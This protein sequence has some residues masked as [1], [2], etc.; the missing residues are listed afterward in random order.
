MNPWQIEIGK[1]KLGAPW[2]V[3]LQSMT[4]TPTMD[5]QATVEQTI[6]I[7][8]AGADI[9]RITAQNTKEAQN[10]AFIKKE[11]NKRSYYIPLV[12]D[13]HF[14]PKAAD[15]AAT[16][17]DKVRIN[18]G[19]Y[20]DKKSNKIEWTH[21]EYQQDLQHI[22]QNLIGLVDI[23]Q[24]HHTA[25]RVGVNHGSLSERIKRN[26]GDTVEGMVESAMEFINIF[27]ELNFENLVISLK[28]SNVL[29]MVEANRLLTKRMKVENS[30]YPLH[31]GVTEAG[32]AEDG[33]IKSALGIGTLLAEGIGDTIRVSL[34]EEPE[35]EI[36]IAKKIVSFAKK[37]SLK[38]PKS[39]QHF[40]RRKSYAVG[41]FGNEQAPVVIQSGRESVA[42]LIPDYFFD[43]SNNSWLSS[44]N[45]Q[46]ITESTVS[47]LITN[48]QN[49][50]HSC[51]VKISKQD[52]DEELQRTLKNRRN[53]VIV[54]EKNEQTS[55]QEIQDIIQEIEHKQIA[56]PLVLHIYNPIKDIED[57][58]ISTTI[59][60]GPILMAAKLDGLWIDSPHHST[61][62]ITFGILQASRLR[63]SKTEYIACPSC[64][65]TLFN[66]QEKLQDIKKHTRQLKGLK[67]AVMGCVVN[68]PGEMAD[69]DYGY[70]GAGPGRVDIYKGHKIMRKGVLEKDATMALLSIIQNK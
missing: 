58:L 13:I 57:L 28:A 9:V 53:T 4:S 55:S 23:C 44:N 10:L 25:I 11:L 24:K 22:K 20:Y 40:T 63:V 5:T 43:S 70:V 7:V 1:L 59:Q 34:T 2:P 51:F 49:T 26:Y 30:L 56:C 32:D 60:A 37:N 33:R 67:I 8:D 46:I 39:T 27:K 62:D 45:K 31:L 15:I 36:P 38:S 52:W 50:K 35:I 12:A 54:L 48:K 69:A 18:P 64:G 61:T 41:A 21:Q 19:N 68:G 42:K 16:I 66:I 29:I 14:N 17:V 47:D 6:R 3:L 65:R